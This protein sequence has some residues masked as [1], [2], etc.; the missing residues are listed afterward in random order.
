MLKKKSEDMMM[1]K[2]IRAS[3]PKELDMAV[4]QAL[5]EGW[6][7]HGGITVAMAQNA[8]CGDLLTYEYAQATIKK[9]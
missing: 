8:L 3:C 7:L 9:N 6:E 1:Y 4:N 5:E 2:T